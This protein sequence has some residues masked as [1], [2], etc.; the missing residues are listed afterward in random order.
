MAYKMRGMEVRSIFELLGFSENDISKS[1]A[2]MFNECS[3]MLE[4]FIKDV[5]GNNIKVDPNNIDIKIQE[6]SNNNGITDIEIGDN[7]EFHIIIEAKK[8]WVLPSIKQLET[9]SKRE[10]FA[11]TLIKKKL[12]VTMSESSREYATHYQGTAQQNNIEIKHVSWKDVYRYASEA[13]MASSN[14]QKRLIKE[15]QIYLRGLMNMQKHDSNWVYVV[16]LGSDKPENCKIS[17]IDIVNKKNKYFH[18]MGGNGWPKEP[19]NYLAFR[20]GGKLQSIHHIDD[21]TVTQ[22][23]STEIPEMQNKIE[24][25]PFFI[26]TLGPAIVPSKEVKTGKIYAS[27]RVWCHLDTLLTSSS[28]SDA[29]DISYAR[30]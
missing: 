10:I 24:S 27:G 17:W 14:S 19:P 3:P 23:L 26:Y 13:Y 1:T 11:N 4:I 9:Y 15:F 29:R 21:Y 2:W 30:G 6:Y 18:P 16:S 5:L 28:I 8:G 22:N 12:I 25:G 20:Y 7:D